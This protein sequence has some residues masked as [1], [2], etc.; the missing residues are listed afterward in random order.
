[1]AISSLTSFSACK[2][3][4]FFYPRKSIFYS[5]FSKL[6]I[7]PNHIQLKKLAWVWIDFF[8]K[9]WN[10]LINFST[11][12]IKKIIHLQ[13]RERLKPKAYGMRRLKAEY[14]SLKKVLNRSRL[15]HPSAV[16][17]LQLVLWFEIEDKS[18][19]A[20]YW[21]VILQIKCCNTFF[22]DMLTKI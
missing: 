7:L 11:W 6:Q 12:I 9:F 10:F 19:K 20:V 4:C 21:P 13:S 2:S 15:R 18:K 3:D 5:W 17:Y 8:S 16:Q 14:S 22:S 1:M